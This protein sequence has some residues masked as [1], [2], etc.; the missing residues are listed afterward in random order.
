MPDHDD[1]PASVS[2]HCAIPQPTRLSADWTRGQATSGSPS[3]P[4][5]GRSPK[6]PRS[7]TPQCENPT[8]REAP[9]TGWDG[10]SENSA[11]QGRQ[12]CRVYP[13]S[14]SVTPASLVPRPQSSAISSNAKFGIFSLQQQMRIKQL[15][16]TL[17]RPPR[18]PERSPLVASHQALASGPRLINLFT[19]PTQLAP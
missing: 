12:C 13:R 7:Q 10:G 2:H 16:E 17:A 3:G 9:A 1:P 6:A 8:Q 15:F 19:R 5:S 14:W 11:R 4:S 18:Q